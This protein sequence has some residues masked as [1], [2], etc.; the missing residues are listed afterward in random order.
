MQDSGTSGNVITY[1]VY[2]TGDDPTFDRSRDVPGWTSSGNWSEY[3]SNIWRIAEVGDSDFRQQMVRLDGVDAMRAQNTGGLNSTYRQYG[4]GSY[5]YIYSTSN[6][7][8]AFSTMRCNSEE[9][10]GSA[11]CLYLQN[12]SY[13]TAENLIFYAG[14][15]SINVRAGTNDIT[16]NS[17]T[18]GEFGRYGV[19][20]D[21]GTNIVFNDCTIASG[22]VGTF[23]YANACMAFEGFSLLSDGTDMT[24]WATTGCTFIN[25]MHGGI[26]I[27]SSSGD[28][29][30]IVITR[31]DFSAP[32]LNYGR[33][34]NLMAWIGGVLSNTEV[35]YNVIH[36]CATR[37]QFN[38][39]ITKIHHNIFKD[40]ART[41]CGID[42]S[43]SNYSKSQALNILSYADHA[44]GDGI[45]IN[46]NVFIRFAEEG[47][48]MEGDGGI[49]NCEIRNNIFWDCGND[50]Y[51]HD[52]SSIWV[53]P[54]AEINTNT[55]T[56]NMFYQD[57]DADIA[58]YRGA[59]YRTVAEFNAGASN[60][61]VINNNT[62]DD[63]EMVAPGSDNFHLTSGSPCIGT[64]IDVGLSLDYDGVAIGDPPDIG[65]YEYISTFQAA[66]AQACNQI[67]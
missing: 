66:W 30:G 36:D 12:V 15:F 43:T 18:L 5:L 35:S 27:E 39:D 25:W 64:G 3:S 28:T 56:H 21:G 48:L 42:W 46:N 16:F 38:G 20:A 52:P 55:F 50:P 41:N 53:E 61:D 49:V 1:G 4:D 33:A 7:S 57:G 19:L 32:E 65:I 45:E 62:N 47:L 29:M 13:V 8:S 54:Q 22:F 60:S 58:F 6:P 51:T 37:S 34:F 23:N 31:C 63:P 59:G 9:A 14:V 10:N 44:D 24:G 17:C 26:S 2:G 67:L 40:G 11:Y